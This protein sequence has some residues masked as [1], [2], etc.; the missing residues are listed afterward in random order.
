MTGG[1]V[2]SLSENLNSADKNTVTANFYASIIENVDMLASLIQRGW[3]KID[4]DQTITWN[5]VN[6]TGGGS[7]TTVNNTQTTNWNQVDDSQG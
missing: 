7:W 6:N 4:D 5:A 2:E 3:I 1:F